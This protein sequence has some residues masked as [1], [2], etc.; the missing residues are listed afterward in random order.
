MTILCRLLAC[1]LL[2]ASVATAEAKVKGFRFPRP[3]GASTWSA[4]TDVRMGETPLQVHRCSSPMP[5]EQ[6]RAFYDQALPKAG[7]RIT[8]LPWQQQQREVLAYMSAARE[9]RAKQGA[10]TS[11]LEARVRALEAGEQDLRRQ[12][13][14]ERGLDRVLVNFEAMGGQTVVFVSQWQGGTPWRTLGVQAGA[15][16]AERWPTTNPCCAPGPA[17]ETAS[18]PMGLPHFP[19]A[20][21]VTSAAAGQDGASIMLFSPERP[22]RV[23]A[24]YEQQLS[25]RGWTFERE[26]DASAPG[27]S[28]TSAWYV[29]AR[30][31]LLLT[32]G[33]AEGAPETI[34]LITVAPRVRLWEQPRS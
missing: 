13:Y 25:L 34:I 28:G 15:A 5:T 24:F 7:W 8:D 17:T 10:D 1:A 18:H 31:R 11:A 4:P 2:I 26:Q 32:V 22:E 23:R 16:P 3:D 12:V 19:G 21:T 33:T 30:R 20:R 14:A 6:L 29:D 27:R 9:A